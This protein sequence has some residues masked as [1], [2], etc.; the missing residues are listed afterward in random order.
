MDAE[1]GR[2]LPEVIDSRHGI[3]LLDAWG[4]SL[5]RGILT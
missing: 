2:D 1:T 4:M 5:E 3:V